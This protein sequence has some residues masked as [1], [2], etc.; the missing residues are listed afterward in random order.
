MWHESQLS[1]ISPHCRE[2]E[3][4]PS[5]GRTP[6][7][8]FWCLR[9]YVTEK[10]EL[11]IL[12]CSE[13]GELRWWLVPQTLQEQ[14]QRPVAHPSWP[15]P[16]GLGWRSPLTTVPKPVLSAILISAGPTQSPTLSWL[17]GAWQSRGPASLGARAPAV[18]GQCSVPGPDSGSAAGAEIL[19]HGKP[20]CSYK[21]VFAGRTHRCL[22]NDYVCKE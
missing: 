7:R 15:E 10:V 12:C 14:A 21:M 17:G 20:N 4:S 6:R 16:P 3:A 1:F 22:N 11:E 19:S 9:R 13:W 18:Q 2:Y 5:S 8:D